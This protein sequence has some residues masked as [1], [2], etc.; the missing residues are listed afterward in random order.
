MSVL[1]E[2]PLHHCVKNILNI[3]NIAFVIY[4]VVQNSSVIIQ[5]SKL[6][7]KSLQFELK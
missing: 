6:N 2:G 7:L 5:F 4:T 1:Q 3:E